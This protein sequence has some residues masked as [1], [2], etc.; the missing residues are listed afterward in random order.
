MKRIARVYLKP[1]SFIHGTTLNQSEYVRFD[2]NFFVIC[3]RHRRASGGPFTTNDLTSS[4]TS[5]STR[6]ISC[7][8]SVH[9]PG[10]AVSWVED[11]WDSDLL[12]SI[13]NSNCGGP[14][15]WMLSPEE[16][17]LAIFGCYRNPT[18]VD[19]AQ[20]LAEL[21]GFPIVIRPSGDNPALTLMCVKNWVP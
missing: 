3:V 15:P 2:P 10:D 4:Q 1:S 13:R 8:M 14:L 12:T 6:N 19:M 7:S 16:P 21:S 11:N 17:S 20:S 18:V 9:E 5:L